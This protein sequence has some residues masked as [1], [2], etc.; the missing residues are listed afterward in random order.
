MIWSRP[1]IIT[2]SSH[3]KWKLTTC[4]V[5]DL[6]TEQDI[7]NGQTPGVQGERILNLEITKKYQKKKKVEKGGKFSSLPSFKINTQ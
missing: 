5:W 4:Q 7:R 1:N 6:L 2:S 3:D